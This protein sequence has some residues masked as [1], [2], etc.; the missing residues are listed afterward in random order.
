ME[1]SLGKQTPL[2]D[3]E[4]QLES[5]ASRHTSGGG[6]HRRIAQNVRVLVEVPI[7]LFG[8]S[9]IVFHYVSAALLLCQLLSFIFLGGTTFP[10]IKNVLPMWKVI[11]VAFLGLISME[12]AAY[13]WWCLQCLLGRRHVY[14]W[15]TFPVY[16]A[17]DVLYDSFF[18]VL[19]YVCPRR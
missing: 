8:A 12:L 9:I 10:D 19:E 17:T 15:F 14:P 13:L 11:P 6:L 3:D 18:A 4:A 7:L 16:E 2:R 1:S 5:P